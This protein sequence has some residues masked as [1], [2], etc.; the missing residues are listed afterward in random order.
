MT[1]RSSSQHLSNAP[2]TGHFFFCFALAALAA[3]VASELNI[4]FLVLM[5]VATAYLTWLADRQNIFQMAFLCGHY[6]FCI[7]PLLLYTYLGVPI[8]A[9]APVFCLLG[10]ILALVLTQ[11]SP[12][13]LGIADVW[14]IKLKIHLTIVI[15][16]LALLVL[17]EGA[18]FLFTM[19]YVV[20]SFHILTVKER[21]FIATGIAYIAGLSCIIIYFIFYSSGFARL[22]LASP[23]FILTL[24]MANSLRISFIKPTI[25]AIVPVGGFFGS[26]IR[27]DAGFNV[28]L[29]MEVAAQDSIANPLLLF[30][31]IYQVRRA[32]SDVA[33]SAWFDQVGL[34]FLGAVP[35]SL[36]SGKPE[37][38]G[39]EYTVENLKTYLVK[40]EHSVA[41]TFAGEHVYYLGIVFGLAGML[42][43]VILV[44]FMWRFLCRY[45]DGYLAVGVAVNVPTFYWGG[46][47]AY[48]ARNLLWLIPALI[49][50]IAAG[51]V[52][53]RKE[54]MPRLRTY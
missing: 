49:L 25:L 1:D 42:V 12:R 19:P 23:I 35:R 29:V 28:G 54:R 52:V 11:I 14:D 44:S 16:F 13:Y 36:W 3:L 32:F 27:S 5:V 31:H 20:I 51:L 40:A 41:A 4:V 53:A 30:D 48:A 38:F 37:G 9:A 26:V 6:A 21:G 39:F 46:M 24:I 17:S 2:A 33:I 10:T 47:Q 7:Y 22:A 15:I 45:K 50:S 18:S 8:I 43:G 34:F